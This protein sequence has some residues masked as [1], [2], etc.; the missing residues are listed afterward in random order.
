MQKATILKIGTCVRNPE[1]GWAIMGWHI[2][3]GD[4]PGI[5]PA[6]GRLGG[7]TPE[8]LQELASQAGL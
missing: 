1:G 8:E 2:Q 4:Y 7:W 3:G 5:D 6:D